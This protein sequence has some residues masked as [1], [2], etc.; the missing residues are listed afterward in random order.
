MSLCPG[1]AFEP[2]RKLP[3]LIAWISLCTGVSTTPPIEEN[4]LDGLR[5]RRQGPDQCAC[6][7]AVVVAAFDAK[8]TSMIHQSPPFPPIPAE[9][10]NGAM[11]FTVPVDFVV[12]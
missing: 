10:K 6:D 3:E 9:I 1:P 2:L 8:A 11:S 5:L 12:R 7:L 4:T